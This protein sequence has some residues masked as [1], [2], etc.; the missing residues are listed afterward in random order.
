MFAGNTA[1]DSAIG[2][3]GRRSRRLRDQQEHP[4]RHLERDAD[5]DQL[6]V[7]S[8]VRGMIFRKKDVDAK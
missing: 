6:P 2:P 8:Q 4:G 1:I 3:Q 7:I 5:Q